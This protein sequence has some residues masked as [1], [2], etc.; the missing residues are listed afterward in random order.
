MTRVWP[1]IIVEENNLQSH[2]RGAQGAGGRQRR[3]QL[4]GHGAGARYRLI[5]LQSD[6]LAERQ[7]TEDAAR[8]SVP[9]TSIAVLPFSNMSG[10]ASRTILPTALSRHH[11][12]SVTYQLALC[13]R[14]QFELRLSRQGR[15]FA[16]DRARAGLSIPGSGSVRKAGNR[17]RITAQLVES[18]NGVCL[19]PS[20]MIDCSMTSSSFRINCHEPDRHHRAE[21]SQDRD[22]A[23]Q[24]QASRKPRRV[25]SGVAGAVDHGKL[26]ADGRGSSDSIAAEGGGVGA[27]LRSCP[28]SPRSCSIFATAAVVCARRIA[29]SRSITRVLQ[30]AQR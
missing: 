1:D 8:S 13:D 17:I 10:D 20:A 16:R 28:C 26:H 18:E 6:G 24:A 25:R 4:R 27:R 19:W 21:P 12:R 22:R 5:G 11:H 9:G 29:R 7:L 3:R 23:C 14:S 30:C 15:G 2:L